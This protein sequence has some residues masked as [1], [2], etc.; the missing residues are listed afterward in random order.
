MNTPLPLRSSQTN[1][2]AGSLMN[3]HPQNSTIPTSM[4]TGTPMN[5]SSS[6]P[7]FQ[8]SMTPGT[9]MN[10]ASSLPPYQTSMAPGTPMSSI[11][12]QSFDNNAPMQSTSSHPY[13]TAT[14]TLAEWYNSPAAKSSTPAT[15]S[16]TPAAN[17]N[18]LRPFIIF[19]GRDG[20]SMTLMNQTTVN[21]HITNGILTDA[22][23]PP[24]DFSHGTREMEGRTWTQKRA[25]HLR[26]MSQILHSYQLEIRAEQLR[27]LVDL[28]KYY[29]FTKLYADLLEFVMITNWDILL[30]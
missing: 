5:T 2:E 23:I 18:P 15:N 24:P 25:V 13:T 16:G 12:H 3:T 22:S 30:I 19:P 7:P 14:F 29:F 26:D 4:T 8:T 21:E 6:L 10:T 17:T 28:S 9:L 11:P 1:M 20:I 27:S